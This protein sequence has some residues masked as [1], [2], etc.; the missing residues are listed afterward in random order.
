MADATEI[1]RKFYDK[2]YSDGGFASQRLY[3]NEELLR[4]M[5]S[6]FFPLAKEQRG[7]IRILEIGCGSC[8]NLWMIAR[9]GFDAHGLDLSAE[10]LRLGAEMMRHWQTH[11]TLTEGSMDKLPYPDRSFDAVVDVFSSYCL[12]EAAFGACLDEVARVL[13]PSGRYFSYAPSKNSDS[14]RNPGPSAFI[15]ASTLDGIRRETAPYAGQ[16]Y[17]FRFIGPDEYPAL[18]EQRGLQTTRCERIGRTYNDGTEYFEFVSL[19]ALKPGG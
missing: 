17:P 7:A 14:F 12:P 11:A 6:H 1:T 16:L 3:P 4:F 5:G 10:S 2:A 19:H 18:L 8:A 9:E 15:D 13:R